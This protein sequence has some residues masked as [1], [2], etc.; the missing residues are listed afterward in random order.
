MLWLYGPPGVGKSRLARDIAAAEID[1]TIR[2]NPISGEPDGEQDPEPGNRTQCNYY[3]KPSSKWWDGYGNEP[4]VIWD[5]IPRDY[6]WDELL[7][8]LDRYPLKVEVKGGFAEFNST[9][10]IITSNFTP[11][12]LFGRYEN[13]RALERRITLLLHCPNNIYN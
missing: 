4:I 6:P 2:E 10:I 9:M 13:Y 11:A 7:H 5:E 1:E 8:L 3:A 12:A